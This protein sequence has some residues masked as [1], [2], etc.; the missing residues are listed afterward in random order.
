VEFHK[1]AKAV[2]AYAATG[3]IFRPIEFCY[4]GFMP[5]ALQALYSHM[6][7]APVDDIVFQDMMLTWQ[8]FDSWLVWDIMTDPDSYNILVCRDVPNAARCMHETSS[9]LQPLNEIVFRDL[10]S[11]AECYREYTN[12]Y[13]D[14]NDPNVAAFRDFSMVVSYLSYECS[15]YQWFRKYLEL[16]IEVRELIMHEYLLLERKAGRLSKHQ[17]YDHWG[18][19]CCK[20]QYPVVLIACDNQ[21]ANVFPEASHARC[22]A[23][24][25]PNLAFT[26]HAMHD[27][28]LVFMLRKTQRFDF[29]YIFGN[30]GFKIATWFRNFLE[31]IPGDASVRT[32]RHLAFPHMH[33]FN[34]QRIPP[35][36]TNPS[37]ELAVSCKNLRKLDMTFHSSKVTVC[38]QSTNWTRRPLT[39]A[40]IVDRFKLQ[41]IFDCRNLEEVYIDSIYVHPFRGGAPSDLD[42]VED[43]SKWMIKGF[44]VRRDPDHGIQVELVRRWGVWRGRVAGVLV[45]VEEDDLRAAR[46]ASTANL[47]SDREEGT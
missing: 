34:H 44:L 45:T 32:V 15:C 6:G 2:M 8:A 35:A 11:T 43:L 17:H 28:V 46:Q 4:T 31:A 47:G 14:W 23:G 13:D 37:I 41:P 26:N 9:H 19:S 27:E 36:L 38:D 10:A 16:P 24:W 30:T 21:N 40:A 5:Q 7:L 33:W 39:L 29:K 12:E 20:W 25:L 1:L 42:V 22:P 3:S 18:N